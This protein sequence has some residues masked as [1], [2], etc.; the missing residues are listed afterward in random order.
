ADA[1]VRERQNSPFAS[2][3]DLGNAA[4][5]ALHGDL[6]RVYGFPNGR[7][8]M[9]VVDPVT[10]EI[11]RARIV[12]TPA[13]SERPVWIEEQSFSLIAPWEKATLPAH[14]PGFPDPTT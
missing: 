4:G 5:L 10:G 11:A 3:E 1:A 8:A 12:L 2:L 9:R 13:D 14:A 7:F 6:E